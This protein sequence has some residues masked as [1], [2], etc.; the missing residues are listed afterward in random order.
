MKK[1]LFV[2]LLLS[3]FATG[4][5]Y[6]DDIVYGDANADGA[7]DVADIVMLRKKINGEEMPIEFH[8]TAADANQDGEYDVADIVFIRGVINGTIVP[9]PIGGDPDPDPDPVDPNEIGVTIGKWT[10]EDILEPQI[11]EDIE[12]GD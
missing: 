3:F 1:T 4:A 12:F 9:D 10:T 5:A 7:V 11:K 8:V 2:T 6:A